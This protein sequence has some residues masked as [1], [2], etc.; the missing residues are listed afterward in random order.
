M[1]QKVCMDVPCNVEPFQDF[2]A[3]LSWSWQVGTVKVLKR[4]L[5]NNGDPY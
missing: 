4:S 1:V 2:F 3:F 5:I